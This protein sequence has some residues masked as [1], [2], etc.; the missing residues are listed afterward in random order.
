MFEEFNYGIVK[1]VLQDENDD[2]KSYWFDTNLSEREFDNFAQT[3]E[4][5]NF[6]EKMETSGKKWSGVH[7]GTGGDGW[8]GYN[9]YEIKNF[10]KAIKMWLDFFIS[11]GKAEIGT[12]IHINDQEYFD[13]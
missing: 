11:N 9:S 1:F 3:P 2:Y 12:Q 8:V 4:F 7:D 6:M 13:E 10:N 5:E